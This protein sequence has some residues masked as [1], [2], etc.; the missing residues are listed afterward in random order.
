MVDADALPT[1]KRPD[2]PDCPNGLVVWRHVLPATVPATAQVFGWLVGGLFAYCRGGAGF[3]YPGL[4]AVLVD[5]VRH[6]DSP[7]LEGVGLLLAAIIIGALVLADA[8]GVLA[9]LRRGTGSDDHLDGQ[10]G[11]PCRITLVLA[12]IPG[13]AVVFLALAGPWLVDRDPGDISGP[14]YAAPGANLLLGSDFSGRDVV[15]RVLACGRPLVI[16]PVVAVCLTAVPGMA[17]GLLAGYLGGAVDVVVSR[18]D[19]LLLT[20]PPILVL[21]ILLHGWGYTPATLIAVVV[22]TGAPFVSR[23]V[24]AATLPAMRAGYV[25]QAVALGEGTIGIL[26]GRSCPTS[27]GR[28]W[29]MRA[30]G[31]RSR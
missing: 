18:S 9:N 24:R 7:V 26:I 8:I 19:N 14:P 13:A 25:K 2:W 6:H 5:A 10:G 11:G 17:L 31:W 3:N 1:S 4:S 27:S 21:L 29:P 15:A 22:A 20:I 16:I 23:L 30:P 12:A 28:C